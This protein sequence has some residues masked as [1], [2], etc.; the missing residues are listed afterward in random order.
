MLNLS[1]K[2]WGRDPSLTWH[3]TQWS[4]GAVDVHKHSRELYCIWRT[5]CPPAPPLPA[6]PTLLRKEKSI[7]VQPAQRRDAFTAVNSSPTHRVT[8]GHGGGR[9]SAWMQTW[10]VDQENTPLGFFS[11]VI[12]GTFRFSE[13]NDTVF[14]HCREESTTGGSI[15]GVSKP[16]L[17]RGR[18]LVICSWLLAYH[19]AHVSESTSVAKIRQRWPTPILFFPYLVF[20]T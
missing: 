14:S 1:G 16:H 15:T 8:M 11:H 2:V 10:D 12:I 3:K 17:Q 18:S 13:K 5:K 19:C 7:A 9:I 4:K 20:D 6:A